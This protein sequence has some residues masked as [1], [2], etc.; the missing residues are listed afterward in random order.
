MDEKGFRLVI[1]ER[2]PPGEIHFR[3]AETGVL[4]SKI[5]HAE[6]SGSILS[7]EGLEKPNNTDRID[8]RLIEVWSEIIQSMKRYR[9]FGHTDREYATVANDACKHL[10]GSRS[11]E[12]PPSSPPEN[13][14][15]EEIEKLRKAADDMGAHW[16]GSRIGSPEYSKAVRELM[17]AAWTVVERNQESPQPTPTAAKVDWEKWN[18][19][20]YIDALNE[21]ADDHDKSEV[22]AH[23]TMEII[24]SLRSWLKK[25]YAD[26]QV[27][28]PRVTLTAGCETPTE[29]KEQTYRKAA[30]EWQKKA[31]EHA[32][33]IQQL[34]KELEELK[35]VLNYDT[36][37]FSKLT[38]D[39]V[40]KEAAVDGASYAALT[41]AIQHQEIS[42]LK[43]KIAAMEGENAS[44]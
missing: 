13:G 6:S 44:R 33:R 25:K 36:D 32:I 28:D 9:C 1:D 38:I 40:L 31:F 35:K 27:N 20:I 39:K 41:M 34:E 17:D 19:G 21:I 18:L 14:S 12:S 26:C 2:L 7:R 42:R 37:A 15:G 30:R 11:K 23:S 5:T 29:S 43:A 3:D 4:L 24:E 10:A 8:V 16:I 22:I